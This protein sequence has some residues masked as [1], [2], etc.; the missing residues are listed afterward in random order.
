MSHPNQRIRRRLLAALVM[1][2]GLVAPGV[3]TAA[4]AQAQGGGPTSAVDRALAADP[5]YRVLVA[6]IQDALGAMAQADRE[7]M[8]AEGVST[9]R[10]ADDAV[11]DR[12][13]RARARAM[14]GLDSLLAGGA[15][16]RAM[17]K[18]L[19]T[20]W[21]NTDLVRRTEVRAAVLAND[22]NEVLQL[23]VPLATAA[24]RDTQFLRWR[25][26]ALDSLGRPA[27]ALRA[28]QARF[29]LA[30]SDPEGWRALLRGHEL[31]GTLS[32]LRESL[33]RLRLLYPESRAVREYEIE[34]LHRLG[35]NDEAARIA[36]DTTGGTP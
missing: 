15:R 8:P 14:A 20:D 28:R 32:R 30:P 1:G 23:V 24:P 3:V 9:L 11:L 2:A 12:R 19:A 34:V 25:A 27:E 29:E 18:A 21:P 4:T 33:S 22:A 7:L 10:A 31:A 5:T 35:R 6:R 16:G 26:D 17:L 13:A 36:A